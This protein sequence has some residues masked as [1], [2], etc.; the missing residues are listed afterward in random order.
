MKEAVGCSEGVGGGREEEETVV[1][2]ELPL[3]SLRL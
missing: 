1:E 2:V 3:D